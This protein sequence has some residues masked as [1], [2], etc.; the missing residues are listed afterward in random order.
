MIK[1][2]R[3]IKVPVTISGVG[4][5]TGAKVNLTYKPAPENHG[6]KFQRIDIDNKPIIKA[7]I[8]NVTDTV[9]GTN[10]LQNGACVN[11][12][13]HV[14]AALVGLEIDNVL[15]EIDGPET[16]IMDG[17]AKAF[18]V[19][20]SKAGTKEQNEPRQVFE[21]K[22]PIYYK[23]EETKTE[24]FAFP[25]DNFGL[26]VMVDYDSNVLGCQHA[27]LDDIRDF[28]DKIAPS[29]TF[30]FLHELEELLQGDLIKGGD[31]DNAIVVVDKE[32]DDAKWKRLK[33]LFNKPDVE[34]LKE[35][36]L[37]NV[38][39][40]FQNEPA[41]H[42][43]LDI[44]GDLALTGKFINAQIIA[45][46]PGHTT[47]IEF[48][49]KIKAIMKEG[50]KNPNTPIYDPTIPPLYNINQIQ[51][52][53]PH[54]SPF[55]FIDKI[56]NMG[57]DFVIGMKNVTMDEPFFQGHFPEDPI[58]PGVLLVEAMAQTGGILVLSTV[59]D[60][61]NYLTYF[62]KIDKVKFKNKVIPGDTVIFKLNLLSPIRRGICYM[63]GYA[64]VGNKIVM[65]GEMMAQIVK[66][67]NVGKKKK[68]P[69]FVDQM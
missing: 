19:A 14:L 6:Y 5:H 38:K 57:D 48:A 45:S 11:T 43:L 36:I 26:K 59:P 8:D 16:P 64:Y 42:K 66:V 53:L 54:R 50:E 62:L 17:S 31:L 65:E 4:L 44:I 15:I 18:V 41:R 1:M 33:K 22:K 21:L 49:R 55:L 68:D 34:I 51:E 30:V 69:D 35:G 13:E 67:K 10:L 29:R 24:I 52:I 27:S 40:L 23:N 7:D 25:S 32:W 60:P 9:R 20:L 3:T 46:R 39:L 37:N 47:N 2:Q 61:E 28:K 58:M 12:V 56:L 63:G